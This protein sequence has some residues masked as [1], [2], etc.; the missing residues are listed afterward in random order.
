MTGSYRH[1]E[2]DELWVLL[3]AFNEAAVIREVIRNVR[4]CGFHHIIVVD[5]GSS[6]DTARIALEEKTVLLSHP[7]NRG[8]GAVIQTGLLYARMKG[9][10]LVVQ[11]DS[12][13]QHHPEDI[14][15]LLKKL[16]SE[17]CDIVVGSRFLKKNDNIP[18]IRVVYNGISNIITNWFCEKWYSDTQ[19][20]FRM[21][22][23]RAIEKLDLQID[24]FGYCS[25]MII[26]AERKSL[27]IGEVPISVSYTDYSM[28][29]GQD[30]FMGVV[31]ATNL[32][33]KLLFNPRH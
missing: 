19:S 30:F 14:H 7:V 21:F 2:N 13:G 1:I 5:D 9:I 6:D 8:A 26:Q 17:E 29:K 23:R 18:K 27:R 32:F 31:T 16:S 10:N 15:R 25:E 24:G 4:S 12:D 11:M 20:G 33:W 3:P 28:S 22:N